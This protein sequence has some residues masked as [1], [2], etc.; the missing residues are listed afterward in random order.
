MPDSNP[1]EQGGS[2]LSDLDYGRHQRGAYWT[3]CAIAL[4][5]L[6]FVAVAATGLLGVHS[7]QVSAHSGGYTLTVEYAGVARAGLDVPLR[8]R[9]TPDQKFDDTITLSISRDYLAIFET[10]GFHPEPKDTA[11]Q[12]DDILLTFDTPPDGSPFVLDYDAYIQPASQT[13]ATARV[14]V[15]R[16]NDRLTTVQFT[17]FLFP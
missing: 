3:R 4:V 17:T 16:K 10:Q 5:M 2:T 15:M 7:R 6:S 14:S 11:N 13:G 9:V 12:G 1:A 8:I